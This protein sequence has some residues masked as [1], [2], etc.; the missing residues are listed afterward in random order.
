MSALTSEQAAINASRHGWWGT[1]TWKSWDSMI[2]RCNG[3]GSKNDTRLYAERGISFDP[4]WATFENFLADMGERPVG[5]TLE[6]TDNNKGYSK[7]NCVWAS[8]KVQARN[9]SNNSLMELDGETAPLCV[10]AERFGVSHALIR[11]RMRNGMSFKQALTTPKMR[12]GPVP[13]TRSP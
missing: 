12:R 13:Y 3:V 1:G 2:T 9:R 6:R 4:R 8:R 10:F 5:L 7:E 11:Y